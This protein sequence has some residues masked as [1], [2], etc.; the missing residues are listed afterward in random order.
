MLRCKKAGHDQGQE[1]LPGAF[2]S[3]HLLRP[4]RDL[5][6]PDAREF[7]GH[8]YGVEESVASEHE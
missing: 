6:Y 5:S 1:R 3:R 8:S 2:I 7:E 4:S